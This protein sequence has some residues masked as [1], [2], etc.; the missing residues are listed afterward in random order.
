MPAD[1]MCVAIEDQRETSARP[2]GNSFRHYIA[3]EAATLLDNVA[4]TPDQDGDNRDCDIGAISGP[5]FCAPP[6]AITRCHAY[7]R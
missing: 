2:I 3:S 5:V 6:R 1:G 7:G 4:A